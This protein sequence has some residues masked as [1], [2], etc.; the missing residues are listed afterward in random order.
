MQQNK[1]VYYLITANIGCCLIKLCRKSFFPF[2]SSLFLI[3]EQDC[4]CLTN[5][6]FKIHFVCILHSILS[7]GFL[8]LFVSSVE[9][10]YRSSDVHKLCLTRK[11]RR[12]DLKVMFDIFGIACLT[13]RISTIHCTT[14]SLELFECCYLKKKC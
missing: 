11:V 12:F 6:P 14:Q 9:T 4:V 7:I 3:G 10:H 2:C 13:D 5:K 8:L 1:K